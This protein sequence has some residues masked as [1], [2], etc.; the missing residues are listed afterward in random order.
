MQELLIQIGW[1][2]LYVPAFY[3]IGMLIED[4]K[5]NKRGGSE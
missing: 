3:G 5:K 2:C 4:Y 1:A